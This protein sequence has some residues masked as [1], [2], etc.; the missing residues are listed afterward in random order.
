M[1][2]KKS[3]LKSVRLVKQ[4]WIF[5]SLLKIARLINKTFFFYFVQTILN[6]L[7]LR[8]FLKND[9]FFISLNDLSERHY[10]SRKISFVLNNFVRSLFSILPFIGSLLNSR[11]FRTYLKADRINKINDVN[12]HCLKL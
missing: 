12:Q 5:K 2:L 3:W 4:L 7:F 6:C 10:R 11:E 1:R 8:S 9:I